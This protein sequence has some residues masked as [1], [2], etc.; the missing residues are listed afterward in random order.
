M[1]ELT[2][3]KELFIETVEKPMLGLIDI[4]EEH[5]KG[6]DLPLDAFLQITD[7]LMPRYYTI[8]SSNLKYPD[9]VK[10]AIAMTIDRTD[11]SPNK[12][13]QTSRFLKDIYVKGDYKVTKVTNRIFIKDSLFLLP[14]NQVETPIVMVGPG[15][16][17]VPFIGFL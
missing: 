6:M 16:G 2:T 9:E 1:T 15:T 7:R 12:L 8:A 17:V 14:K 3:S 4:L 10:I 11:K 5:H 13:G